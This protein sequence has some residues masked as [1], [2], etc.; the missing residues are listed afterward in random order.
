MLETWKTIREKQNSVEM[1]C[2]ENHNMSIFILQIKANNR[3]NLIHLKK[4][5]K[6]I[7][8]IEIYIYV[9]SLSFLSS[10]FFVIL[11]RLIASNVSYH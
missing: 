1:E 3:F 4:S 2:D 5:E 9:E 7:K 8:Q 10:N 6:T 11:L